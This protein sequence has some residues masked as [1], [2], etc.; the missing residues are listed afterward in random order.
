MPLKNQGVRFSMKSRT[1]ALKSLSG[2]SDLNSLEAG[3]MKLRTLS[4][5][6]TDANGIH[7]HFMILFV[8]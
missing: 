2:I 1:L 7:C 4:N 5:I 8:S 3:I 6:H